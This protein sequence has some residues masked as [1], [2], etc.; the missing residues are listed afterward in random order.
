MIVVRD[1]SGLVAVFNS[2]DPEHLSAR[3]VLVEAALTVIS[4][5]VFL[6]PSHRAE[7]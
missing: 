2:A 3:R 7:P 1:T 4:P 6:D 5:F